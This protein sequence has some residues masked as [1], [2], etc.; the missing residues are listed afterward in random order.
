MSPQRITQRHLRTNAESLL[1]ALRRTNRRKY[2]SG[3]VA[4]CILF[5]L[6]AWAACAWLTR[7][8]LP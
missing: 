4:A 3:I 5:S 7:H 2:R 8:F 1:I 6:F